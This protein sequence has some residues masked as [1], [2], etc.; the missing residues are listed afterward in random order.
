V[1]EE[2]PPYDPPVDPAEVPTPAAE[3]PPVD[4]PGPPSEPGPAPDTGQTPVDT[5][6]AVPAPVVVDATAQ[7]SGT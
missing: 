1:L 2:L 5:A 7:D 3:E 6:P 4:V